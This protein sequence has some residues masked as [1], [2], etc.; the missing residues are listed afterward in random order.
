[1]AKKQKS[2]ATKTSRNP[3]KPPAAAK[4]KNIEKQPDTTPSANDCRYVQQEP[5]NIYVNIAAPKDE[6]WNWTLANKIAL[7][8]AVVSVGLGIFTYL[9]FQEAT[10]QSKAAT[11]AANAAESTVEEYKREFLIANEPLIQ[12]IPD[13]VKILAWEVGKPT[14]IGFCFENLRDIP[15]KIITIKTRTG[16]DVK[17]PDFNGFK[18]SLIAMADTSIPNANQY[19]A[20]GVPFPDV[21]TS[22]IQLPKFFH[23]I[24]FDRRHSLYLASALKYQNIYT[25]SFHFTFTVLKISP[26]PDGSIYSQILDVERIK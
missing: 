1:M 12:P 20:K 23:D 2:N 15:A 16:I 26:R 6:K 5:P 25:D 24:I 8:A 10:T 19:M 13:S 17:P 7:F 4:R 21:T 14:K 22:D 18:D 11:K 3:T 9:L